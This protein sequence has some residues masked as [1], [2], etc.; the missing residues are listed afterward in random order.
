MIEQR[1]HERG[2]TQAELAERAGVSRQWVNA[3]EAAEGNPSFMN[4][5]AVLDALDLELEI[6]EVTPAD[7]PKKVHP[8]LGELVNRHRL[9]LPE[10][11]H[12]L[13]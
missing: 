11:P 10:A 8:D 7:R 3:L 13:K 1:R 9:P 4:L 12:L 6:T 2:F 5:L